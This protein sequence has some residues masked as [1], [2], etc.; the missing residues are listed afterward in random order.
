MV[1]L[2]IAAY[3]QPVAAEAAAQLRQV[4]GTRVSL[5]PPPGFFR[6]TGFSGFINPEGA[7]ILVA[8]LP[9]ASFR[10]LPATSDFRRGQEIGPGKRALADGEQWTLTGGL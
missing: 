2:P 10:S 5:A 6:G 7:S 3:A 1:S 4:E 9:T 8:E